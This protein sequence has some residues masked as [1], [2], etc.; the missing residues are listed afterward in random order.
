MSYNIVRKYTI[1]ASDPE[2][3]YIWMKNWHTVRK[4]RL[5]QKFKDILM[6]LILKDILLPPRYKEVEQGRKFQHVFK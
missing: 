1:L 5:L 3:F 6:H 2:V 4:L